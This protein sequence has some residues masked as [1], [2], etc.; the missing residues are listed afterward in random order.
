MRCLGGYHAA[1]AV[2]WIALGI[3]TGHL[4]EGL[5][6]GYAEAHRYAGTPPYLATQTAPLARSMPSIP[7]IEKSPV[8][9]IL[10]TRHL[11]AGMAITR[12][13]ISP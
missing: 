7:R 6:G 4:G 1:F 11:L 3:F 5:G 13:D 2:T 12:A 9:G 10:A 8:D